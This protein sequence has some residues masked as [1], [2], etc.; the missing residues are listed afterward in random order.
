[1]RLIDSC[2][3]QLIRLKDL[4]GP[5]TRVK[6]K[7]GVGEAPPDELDEEECEDDGARLDYDE[8]ALRFREGLVFKAHRL[9][10]HSTLGLRVITKKMTEQVS[11]T[12]NEHCTS[13]ICL[14]I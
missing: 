1:M 3:T 13:R 10:Y 11:T 2:I 7:K 5:V 9:W 4:L 6:K 12:M 8:R 14:L